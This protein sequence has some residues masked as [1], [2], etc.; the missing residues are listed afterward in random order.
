MALKLDPVRLLIADD[1]GIGKTVEACLIARELLDRGEVRSLAVLC[2][3]HLAEQWQAELRSKFNIEAELVLAST[4]TRLERDLRAGRIALRALPVPDRLDRPHQVR[5]PPRRFPARLP[6]ARDRRRGPHL[7]IARRRRVRPSSAQP[8]VSKG[9]PAISDRHLI[10][11]TATPHSGK[12]EAFRSLLALLKPEFA[13]LPDDLS[14]PRPPARAPHA[15][16][17]LRSAPARRHPPLSGRRHA[18]SR[19][20][21]F[22]VD[23][24]ALARLQAALRPRARAA[25]ARRC[26]TTRAVCATASACGGGR[27]WPCCARWPPAPPRRPQRSAAAPRRPAPK[28]PR[29]PT[30]SAAAPS[31]TSTKT[32]QPRGSTSR[33]AATRP[34]PKRGDD[35]SLTAACSTGRA[36]PSRSA[37]TRTR[38]S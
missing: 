37:A 6:R 4:V 27:R 11:V 32:R 29:K 12:E 7:R 18:L 20:V 34:S 38:S 31:S 3:P 22:R 25:P 10:L 16:A 15:R 24:Q 28:P 35:A 9:S 17:A 21:G 36:R 23:L 2:P 33:P 1:V 5:P 19:S 30:R 26:S 13:D 8:A 14:G